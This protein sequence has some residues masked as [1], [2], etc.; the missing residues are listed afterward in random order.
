[1]SENNTV[2][3][4]LNEQI[5]KYFNNLPKLRE[6]RLIDEN[7]E[8]Q[9]VVSASKALE[10]ARSL[11]LDLIEIA[12]NAQPPVCKILDYGKYKYQQS[13]KNKELASSQKQSVLKT[14]TFGVMIDEHD[15]KIKM[16]SAL[17]FLRNG[18][19]VKIIIRLK[20]REVSYPELAEALLN[21][22]IEAAIGSGI[23]EKP[24]TIDGKSV[25]MILAPK[26]S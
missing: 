6:V 20:G 9:G 5:L 25:M 1:M 8:Q 16:I 13:K 18:D 3:P 22:I 19:K 17:K 23:V 7:G 10:I 26:A 14:L 24:A 11:N 12:P 4:R 2:Q 21:K 15:L